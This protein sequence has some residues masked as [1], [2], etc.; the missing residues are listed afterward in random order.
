[1]VGYTAGGIKVSSA[2]THK[3]YRKMR[4]ADA[5]TDLLEGAGSGKGG[6]RV[7]DRTPAL[8]GHPRSGVDHLGF[9]YAHID[10]TGTETNLEI[11]KNLKTE[12]GGN[13]NHSLIL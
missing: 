8:H 12:V 1:M 2:S 13:Q 7:G 3:Y 10:V 5:I 6:Y 4:V 11:I 9:R